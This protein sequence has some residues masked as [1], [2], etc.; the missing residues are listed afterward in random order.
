MYPHPNLILKN[1]ETHYAP[2][3]VY[4]HVFSSFVFIQSYI[5]NLS[6]NFPNCINK[7]RKTFRLFQ[8]PPNSDNVN[9]NLHKRKMIKLTFEDTR[10]VCKNYCKLTEKQEHNLF[11]LTGANF[12]YRASTETYFGPYQASNLE[13]KT[14]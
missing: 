9:G 8:S 12:G 11:N 6:A 7:F 4:Q 5:S 10:K 14:V 1:Q 13:L 2:Y 3:L